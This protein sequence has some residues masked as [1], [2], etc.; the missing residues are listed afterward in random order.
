MEWKLEWR[1][2]RGSVPVN[3]FFW[4]SGFFDLRTKANF[5]RVANK[6]RKQPTRYLNT[7]PLAWHLTTTRHKEATNT[8]KSVLF[9]SR[10][11]ATLGILISSILFYRARPLSVE[12]V[13]TVS[14]EIC[15]PLQ[16]EHLVS[17]VFDNI[18]SNY[19]SYVTENYFVISCPE[20][21]ILFALKKSK[22]YFQCL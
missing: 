8:C 19:N 1:K 10:L 9:R 16:S 5:W 12:K 11:P 17:L 3:V 18:I 15:Q 13:Y 14:L 6:K 22:S 20:I 21:T 4:P 2:I 7:L